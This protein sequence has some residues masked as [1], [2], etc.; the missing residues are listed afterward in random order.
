MLLGSTVGGLCK[1]LLFMYP[2]IYQ[3]VYQ[4][5]L[6]KLSLLSLLGSSFSQLQLLSHPTFLW[7]PGGSAGWGA[8]GLVE[9]NGNHAIPTASPAFGLKARGFKK[10][11]IQRLF[12]PAVCV[13]RPEEAPCCSCCCWVLCWRRGLCGEARVGFSCSEP[14]PCAGTTS[15]RGWRVW[16]HQDFP[17][18]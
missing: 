5:S 11:K 4:K 3:I 13:E 1:L 16:P 10:L 12:P 8:Q 2:C 9:G 15:V 17:A 6:E 7:H 18:T 14:G